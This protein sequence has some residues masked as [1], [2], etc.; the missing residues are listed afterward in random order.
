M[1]IL[2]PA[3]NIAAR[4]GGRHRQSPSLR[5]IKPGRIRGRAA[6]DREPWDRWRPAGRRRA[7]PVQKPPGDA[8]VAARG[9]RDS[10]GRP[11]EGADAGAMES[12]DRL[13]APGE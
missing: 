4:P 1:L 12:A 5:H 11:D 9:D 6:P 3:S 8:Q 13:I 10:V 7:G 2:A